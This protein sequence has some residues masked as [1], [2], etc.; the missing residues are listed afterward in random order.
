VEGVRAVIGAGVRGTTLQ[1]KTGALGPGYHC[2]NEADAAQLLKGEEGTTADLSELLKRQFSHL[3]NLNFFNKDLI[4]FSLRQEHCDE[5]TPK[6][7]PL[8][9]FAVLLAKYPWPS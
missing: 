4:H 5:K 9:H 8:C 1:K 3:F 6:E 7:R 2:C